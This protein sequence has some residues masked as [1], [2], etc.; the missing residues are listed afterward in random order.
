MLKKTIF[1]ALIFMLSLSSLS[2]A[3]K[4]MKDTKE[5]KGTVVEKAQKNES[6][7]ITLKNNSGENVTLIAKDNTSLENIDKGDTV[8]A[9]YIPKSKVI[10]SIS[11]QSEGDVQ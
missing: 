11:E 3:S 2:M 7:T 1:I 10:K 6:R 4:I 5:I 9:Q 8:I